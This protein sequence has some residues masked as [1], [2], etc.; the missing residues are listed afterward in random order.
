[1]RILKFLTTGTI[2]IAVNL[3][4]FHMLYVL[5]VPY[6]AGSTLGFLTAMCV[7]FFLQK[8]WTFE[9]RTP[10]RAHTQFILYV[11]LALGNLAANTLIVYLLVEYAGAHYL[12][13]QTIGA[14]SVALTS[15]LVYRSYI[16]TD[17]L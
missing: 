1:M 9:E 15:Y 16:F 10:E 12:V 17:A 6:L 7:G 2:G 14:G 8:Y 13:A 11:M 5:G 4:V 3:G